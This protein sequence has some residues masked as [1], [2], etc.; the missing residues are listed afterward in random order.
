MSNYNQLFPDPHLELIHSTYYGAKGT[1]TS[2]LAKFPLHK[3][4]TDVIPP[5]AVNP[6]RD[7]PSHSMKMARQSY[8]VNFRQMWSDKAIVNKALYRLLRSLLIIHL[9]PKRDRIFKEKKSNRRN[10]REGKQV[11]TVTNCNIYEAFISMKNKTRNEIRRLLNTEEK[12]KLKFQAKGRIEK[13]GGCQLRIDTYRNVLR[14]E[15]E[16]REAVKAQQQQQ[17]QQK[18]QQKADDL[19]G[20]FVREEVNDEV[21]TEARLREMDSDFTQREVDV[22][23]KILNFVQPY[24][25]SKANYSSSQY[26]LSFVLMANKVLKAIGYEGQVAKLV[27]I[28]KPSALHAFLIDTT[29]LYA[30]FFSKK[31]QDRMYLQDFQGNTIKSIT[32]LANKDAAADY[33]LVS[34]NRIH[35]LPGLET[36]RVYGTYEDLTRTQADKAPEKPIYQ[37]G[38]SML[39]DTNN[40]KSA[41]QNRLNNQV[42]QLDTFLLENDS[43][44]ALKRKWRDNVDGERQR[45]YQKV[46]A[47]KMEKRQ[48][49]IAIRDTKQDIQSIKDKFMIIVIPQPPRR[50]LRHPLIHIFL[51]VNHV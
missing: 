42:K 26:Q 25:P 7:L 14:R 34:S 21:I 36:V 3:A 40:Q 49:M 18:Q 44:R 29:T 24:I 6:Y 37:E 38:D 19:T 13:A 45:W 11:R 9:S 4:I 39:K 16:E 10:K 51:K 48:L 43:V 15:T 27:P 5:S 23:M 47:T 12:R 17:Q 32:A 22:L 30:L 28:I 50:L 20:N 31:A 33:G 41:L 46:E 8:P 2:S 35:I 1:E